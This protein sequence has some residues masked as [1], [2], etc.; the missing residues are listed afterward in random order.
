MKA[1]GTEMK[2]LIC[3]SCGLPFREDEGKSRTVTRGSGPM[4]TEITYAEPPYNWSADNGYCLMCWLV[5][6]NPPSA[7][8][9]V[10]SANF[11]Q[12]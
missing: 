10:E 1:Q 11:E 4:A 9:R 3:M 2:Q 7:R 12:N 6:P 8:D 5:A